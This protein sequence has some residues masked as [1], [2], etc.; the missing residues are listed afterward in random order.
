[1]RSRH[2]VEVDDPLLEGPV[3][4]NPVS[5]DADVLQARCRLP[6]VCGDADP[7]GHLVEELANLDPLLLVDLEAVFLKGGAFEDLECL[8]THQGREIAPIACRRNRIADTPHCDRGP[9]AGSLVAWPDRKCGSFGP[10]GEPPRA[11]H[12]G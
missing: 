2:H 10:S 1:M 7:A 9:N 5:R 11:V 12:R 4:V 6:E 8:P 3:A